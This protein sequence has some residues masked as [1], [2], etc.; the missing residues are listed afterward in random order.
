MDEELNSGE[1]IRR[2]NLTLDWEGIDLERLRR[3]KQVRA[4]AKRELTN[5]IKRVSNALTVGEEGKEA[6]EIQLVEEGLDAAF[7]NFTEAWEQYRNLLDD[8]DDLE[9]AAAYFQEAKTKYLCSKDRVALWLEAKKKPLLERGDHFDIKPKDSI[10]SISKSKSASSYR[11][12]SS[13]RRSKAAIEEKHFNNATRMASLRAEASMLEHHQSIASEELKISQLKERLALDI[14]LAKL[15]AEERVCLEFKLSTGSRCGGE[16]DE[17]IPSDLTRDVLKTPLQMSAP[18]QLTADNAPSYSTTLHTSA[19]P[20]QHSLGVFA[21]PQGPLASLCNP[22]LQSDRSHALKDP[23]VISSAPSQQHSFGVFA[24]SQGPL[25]SLCNPPLQS[26]RSH[27]LKDPL[28]ISSAPSQQHSFGVF[29]PSQGPL[30]SLCNPPLQSD[31]SHALKDPLVISSA[32]SQQHSFGVFAPSQGPLA[33]LCNPPLQSDRSHALK[34]PLVISSAPSQQHSFGVFAP[35][36]GPLAS[37]CNPPLQSDRSHALKDPLVISSAPP[38]QHSLGVLAPP[39]R[40]LVSFCDPPLQSDRSHALKDPLVISSAPPQQH[41]LGVLAPPQRPLVSF[42]DPPLQS[43]QSHAFTDR[44]VMSSAPPQKQSF[45]FHDPPRNPM[46]NA[47]VHLWQPDETPIHNVVP[48]LKVDDPCSS[49]EVADPPP[50]AGS[51]AGSDDGISYLKAM[52]S[53]ATAAL[54]PKAELMNFDGNPLNYFLFMSSFENNVEKSTQDFSKRLQLLIQFCSGKA[55]KAIQSCVLLQPLEGYLQAKKILSERFGGAYKISRTWIKKITDGAQIKPGD[56]DALQ[57]L[58]DELESCEITLQATGRLGQLNNEDSLVRILK[59]CPMYVRSRWQSRVQELRTQGRDPNVQ[60][61][62]KLI[63]MAASEKCDPVYGSLMDSDNKDS[64]LKQKASNQTSTSKT[65]VNFSVQTGEGGKTNSDGCKCYFCDKNHRLDSCESFKLEDGEKQFKLI[66]QKKL[67]DNCLSSFHFSAGCKRRKACTIPNCDV[68]RKHMASIHNAVKEFERRRSGQCSQDQCRSPKPEQ[69]QFSGLTSKADACSVGQGLPVVPIKV[70]CKGRNKVVTTYALLDSGSTASF[71]DNVLLEELGVEGKACRIQLATIDGVRDECQTALVSLEIMDLEETVC[72]QMDSV[73]STKSLNIPTSAIA[74]QDDVNKWP[75]LSGIMVPETIADGKVSLLI[76]VDVPEA[77]EPDEMRKSE[78]GGP[79]AVKTKFGWTLNG[80]LGRHSFTGN[81]CFFSECK[82]GDDL[83]QEQLLK[84]FNREFN[85]LTC[86]NKRGLS[87]HDKQAMK[88]LEESLQFINGHYQMAIPW[89][90]SQPYLPNNREMAEQRL[91]C[92]KRRL[93]RDPGLRIRY[94]NFIDDLLVKGHA[95]KVKDDK[96]RC[97]TDITW[98]LPHHN[99]VNPKKPE[100]IRVVF[101]CAAKCHGVSLNSKVLQGPNLTNSLIGVLCRFRQEHV[102]LVADVESMYHQVCVDPKDIDALRFLWFPNGDLSK[103]PEEYQMVVHLFGGIWSACCAN[104]ALKRTALDNASKFDAIVARTIDKNFYVDDMLKSVRSTDEAIWMQKQL[105]ELLA[106]GGFH[107]TKWSSSSRKVLD[108]IPQSER[109]KELKNINIQD[110]ALPVERTLGLEWHIECDAFRFKISKKE[111]P[112]TRRGILSIISSIFDPL[113]FIAP[114]VLPAKRLL[115]SSCQLLGWDEEISGETLRHWNNWLI[116]MPKLEEFFVKRCI[117][118]PEFGACVSHEIHHFSDASETG[119]GTVSYLRTVHENGEINSA[120]LFAKSRLAPLKRVTIPRLE[121]T[122][123]TLAV[124][125][126]TMLKEELEIKLQK[127]VFWTDSTSVLRYINNKDKRFHTFV[128][129]RITA[130]HEGS[131]PEQWKYVPTKSNPAD[132][133][134]RGMS[135][136]DLLQSKRWMNGPEF[137][138]QTSDTWPKWNDDTDGITEDDVEVK[139]MAQSNSVNISN[140]RGMTSLI[141]L[142]FSSWNRLKKAISWILR[143]KHWLLRNVRRNQTFPLSKCI[144]VSDIKEAEDAIIQCVQRECFAEEFQSLQSSEGA[145]KKSSSLRRL[146]PVIMNGILCVGGR[147]KHA[148]HEYE[149]MKHPVI[150][151]K[152]HHVSN[153]IIQHF[154]EVSGHS[155]QE[156]VLSII[157]ECYWIIQA[158]VP[159]RKICRSCFSCKKRTQAPCQQKMADLPME[160]ATPDKPPFTFVGVDYFGPF[161]V[162]RS[163]TTEKRYGVIFT[164]LAVR[165]IHIEIANSLDTDSFINALR[166]FIARRGSPQE[167]RSDNG[168]NFKGGERELRIAMQEWNQ[169]Q[170]HEFLLQHNVNWI[171]NPPY[172][173]HFGGIWERLIRSIRHV[174]KALLKVQILNDESLRTLMCEVESVINS[175]PLTK[176][177]DDPSDLNALTPNHL[178]LLKTNSNLPPGIFCKQDQY[179]RRRW[180][181]VQYL[182]NVFWRRWLREYLPTLQTRQKWQSIRP[183]ISKDDIVLVVDQTTP[184]SCW[185]LGVV[186]DVH[187]GRDGLVRSARVKTMNTELVRPVDKLCLLE[188]HEDK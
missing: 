157:R 27:A 88:I 94:T 163:R 30:A 109:S 121:L 29:A 12:K 110:D 56:G 162:R 135:A 38:Q 118:V 147:L 168:S 178:L 108:S 78:N 152:R 80:P 182:A 148:P 172:A 7:H 20:Q 92:L 60:D 129:N 41:S 39:Q 34:D 161:L 26:D 6:V 173:S 124:K 69:G 2:R 167:I 130:I 169:H 23:L 106:C 141:F 107:L 21:P 50:R 54:L 98:Y 127:S 137:L 180:K 76:G 176:V 115:Q 70:R 158:R 42:C 83:L 32:P 145:V 123:A 51:R 128:A 87:V 150:L 156:Y 126:D 72:I 28:V 47:N 52:K 105:M 84:Y 131:D 36:Q 85:Q 155:G 143:Y 49:E 45:V 138:L 114:F 4:N 102:A 14:Q 103:E 8:D 159:V 177:S 3:L 175:R 73:F 111:R 31:R 185:P 116:E 89:K 91:G 74:Q 10:S 46:S 154:H 95:R 151:P 132:D 68:R 16:F 149:H 174:L 1:R 99:V 184:R 142:H 77:L 86:D 25:A 165:A 40:P 11:S 48:T 71:C 119:Y 81:S 183:N 90:S 59:R 122:A 113:G 58:A 82:S 93:S 133:A 136:D 17:T 153:L 65:K 179:C 96:S 22:P 9:E 112:A 144:T 67:C 134:S 44:L 160:R 171:F 5:A 187:V 166:R 120:F 146:D 79:F 53:L 104:F 61:I 188:A 13:S 66:R 33:S 139:G 43:D 57:D 55:R 19:P 125:I 15:E 164:C 24:P 97:K 75:Y 62:R 37:L 18:P 101:D 117:K 100:K 63:R 181:Q 140:E 186:L 64:K 170:V 35:S